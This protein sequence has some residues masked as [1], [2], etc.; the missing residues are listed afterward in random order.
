LVFSTQP[1]QRKATPRNSKRGRGG[2]NAAATQAGN[3][4]QSYRETCGLRFGTWKRGSSFKPQ[5]SRQRVKGCGKSAPA[6]AVMPAARRL[7]WPMGSKVRGAGYT[8]GVVVTH[9]VAATFVPP[10][11]LASPL[12]RRGWVIP[13]KPGAARATGAERDGSFEQNRGYGHQLACCDAVRHWANTSGDRPRCLYV[14][15]VGGRWRVLK[16]RLR[17][18]LNPL[19]FKPSGALADARRRTRERPSWSVARYAA[20]GRH[21]PRFG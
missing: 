2:G 20:A 12:R 18:R 10:R 15:V 3:R 11:S 4:E 21:A 9:A 1:W 19:F 16:R 8:V 6:S 13:I 5:A 17:P 14:L 7:R